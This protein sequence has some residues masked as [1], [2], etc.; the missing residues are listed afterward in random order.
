[1]EKS[2]HNKPSK[3]KVAAG[4]LAFFFKKK[5][6]KKAYFTFDSIYYLC[7]I[8]RLAREMARGSVPTY[9]KDKTKTKKEQEGVDF[10]FYPSF[11]S[12]FLFFFFWTI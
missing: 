9:V 10:L 2:L 1:M 3:M 7:N 8:Q 12:F 4:I 11:F 6:K 5:K